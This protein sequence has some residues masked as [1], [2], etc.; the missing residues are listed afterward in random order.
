MA[1]HESFMVGQG[2]GLEDTR[3]RP[4]ARSAGVP[5]PPSVSREGPEKSGGQSKF[6]QR[7]VDRILRA[8]RAGL[9]QKQAITAAGIGND[10]FYRWKRD[11]PEFAK[12]IEAAREQ[13]REDALRSI[14]AAGEED[15]KATAAWLRFSFRKDYAPTASNQTQVA[16]AVLVCDEE[17]RKQIQ[18]MRAKLLEQQQRQARQPNSGY[19]ALPKPQPDPELVIDIEPDPEPIVDE[20]PERTQSEPEQPRPDPEEL[21]PLTAEAILGR[22]RRSADFL[23][24]D[25]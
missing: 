13:A 14:R 19:P 24:S 15:W 12:A 22:Y 5:V 21:P 10:T 17:T 16:Q 20:Q 6:T 8:L 2:G 1:R 3:G 11:N 25:D 18:A 7:R 4:P 23:G 9:D